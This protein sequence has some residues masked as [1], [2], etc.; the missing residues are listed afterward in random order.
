[1]RQTVTI[2]LLLPIF[3]LCALAS[4]AAQERCAPMPGAP[5]LAP[6]DALPLPLAK[7]LAQWSQGA[8][9][10]IAKKYHAVAS[11]NGE[12]YVFGG[13]TT[14]DFYNAKCYKYNPL[15]D[16]WSVLADF[17]VSRW[18]WG[19]AQT[20]KGKIYLFAGLENL[21]A[22]HKPVATVWEYNPA[23]DSYRTLTPIPQPQAWCASGVIDG[24][25]YV[26]GGNGTSTS[27]YLNLVQVY[28]P[29]DDSWS[30]AT[31]Y[32]KLVRWCSAASVNNT[33]VVTAGYNTIYPT[34]YV[35]DTYVGSVSGG[36]LAWT[37]VK[38]YP[39]GEII[40]PS[41]VGVG[42]NAYFFGGRPSIDNNRPCT[43]RSFRYIPATN[44][45][46]VL[47]LKPTGEQTMVQAGTD[48]RRIIAPGGEDT[49]TVYNSPTDP[50][51]AAL[52]VTEIFDPADQAS[53]LLILGETSV[54][55]V[56]KRGPAIKRNFVLKNN[57]GAALTW[58]MTVTPASPWL[59]LSKSSGS[60]NP[61]GT[62]AVELTFASDGVASGSYAATLQIASN[63]AGNPSTD[64]PVTFDLQDQD[65]DTAMDILLEEG[66][67]TW[68]GF[69]PYGGDTVKA[70]VA[71]FPGRVHAISYHG[72]SAT[73]PMLTPWVGPWAA[74][75]GLTGWPGATANRTVQEG[76]ASMMLSG[77]ETWSPTVGQMLA[78]GR[79]PISLSVKAGGC[80]PATHFGWL[81]VDIFFHQPMTANLRIS[82]AQVED[83]F[84]WRQSFYPPSGGSQ[85][86][87]PYIH[88]NVLRQMIPNDVFG[89][90]VSAGTRVAS[91][92]TINKTLFFSSRD[93]VRANSR[94]V[95]FVHRT[96]GVKYGEVLQSIE[97]ELAD[98]TD[99]TPAA[100]LASFALAQNYPNPFNP[101]TLIEYT[102]PAAG[103]ATLEV[104]DPLGRIVRLLAQGDQQ[105]GV[106]RALF[107]AAGLPSGAYF[108]TLRSGTT[109]LTRKMTLLK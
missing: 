37:K 40:Y 87:Y 27:N 2:F 16:R 107:D 90:V 75:V 81:S 53:P 67:G 80:D 79:S 30:T 31:N 12:V 34:Y 95:I 97:H 66:T 6:S 76:A 62:D 96:D 70:I 32:P 17:P 63:D 52:D 18:L 94:F 65:I 88:E 72:G 54:A 60:I 77:R 22:S 78:T 85:Y 44:M 7:P 38:D 57:G 69:C 21:W 71:R 25:I 42:D 29:A 98:L 35:K 28:D 89:E 92:S 73:E 91:Q 93:S 108:Y 10:P 74:L 50:R 49:T 64:I 48:G 47:P 56:M 26:I 9:I 100:G 36:T 55:V 14:G 104:R 61:L 45:W 4:A 39:I 102:L 41:G 68:C 43:R 106:H 23:T 105:A 84:N 59:T 86:L 5:S 15:T 19:Q 83:G 58:S 101:S 103:Y 1:M 20:V 3:I 51:Q 82:V 8:K 13:V 33:I 99:V 11:C 109:T 46:D 24:K